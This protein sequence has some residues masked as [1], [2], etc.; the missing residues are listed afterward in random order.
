MTP[1]RSSKSAA[2]AGS[3]A[4]IADIPD[5]NLQLEIIISKLTALETLPA[6]VAALEKLLQD[7]NAKNVALQKQVAAKDKIIADLTAKTN[8]LE[9]YNCSWSVRINNIILPNGDKTETEVVMQSVFDKAL[10]PIF[11]GAK[12]RGLITSIPDCTDVL[13]TAHILPLKSS[14]RP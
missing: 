6:K 4:A 13:E 2:G 11:E 7:S 1:G 3:A 12:N 9:Q 5:T 8:S 10:R 14:D